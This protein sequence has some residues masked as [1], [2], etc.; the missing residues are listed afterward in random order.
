MEIRAIGIFDFFEDAIFK[1]SYWRRCFGYYNYSVVVK[2]LK[3]KVLTAKSFLKTPE[4]NSSES[5][6][7]LIILAT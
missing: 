2:M 3:D 4:L 1:W 6:L 5:Q 7:I